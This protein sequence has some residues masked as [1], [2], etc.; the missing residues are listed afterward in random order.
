MMGVIVDEDDAI[1]TEANIKTTLGTGEGGHGR[2]DLVGAD[3]VEPG[4][5]N[6]CDTVLDI[7]ADRYAKVDI[8][9]ACPVRENAIKDSLTVTNT[10]VLGVKVGRGVGGGVG[11]ATD[12]GLEAWGDGDVLLNDQCATRPNE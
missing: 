1:V 7:D 6:G 2:S 4:S 11:I 5:S 12:I 3:T 10:D 9:D 8:G